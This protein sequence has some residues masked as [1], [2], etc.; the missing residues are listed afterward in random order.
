[1]NPDMPWNDEI[2]SAWAR[3][4][5]MAASPGTVGLMQP[6]VA[7]LDVRALV[8]AARVPTLV[9][10]HTDD[11]YI[12]PA[13]GRYLADHIAGAKYVEIPGRNVLHFVEPWRPSFQEI[14]EFLTGSQTDVADDRVRHCAVHRHR[15]LDAS[16]FG[17]RRP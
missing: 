4:E 13:R 8:P 5:R 3:L 10:H 6:L 2:R 7:E 14:S 11:Q 15:G 12:V 1:M 17:D 9:V 16:G